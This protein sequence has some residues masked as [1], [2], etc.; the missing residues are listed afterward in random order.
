MTYIANQAAYRQRTLWRILRYKS[1]GRDERIDA[2]HVPRGHSALQNRV[3]A[4]PEV[5]RNGAK[6][7]GTC[8]Q[9]L[10]TMENKETVKLEPKSKDEEERD[11]KEKEFKDQSAF[12]P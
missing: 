1:C 9:A 4:I 3:R 5:C 6:A 2:R 11:R 10:H 12:T 8:Q 7:H